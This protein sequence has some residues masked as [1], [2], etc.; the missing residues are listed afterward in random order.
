MEIFHKREMII[1]LVIVLALTTSVWGQPPPPLTPDNS[2]A[3]YRPFFPNDLFCADIIGN[4][5]IGK[6]G[7][8]VGP[9]TLGETTLDDLIAM[10]ADSFPISIEEGFG[11]FEVI[12]MAPSATAFNSVIYFAYRACV[13]DGRIIVVEGSIQNILNPEDLIELDTYYHSDDYTYVPPTDFV[14]FGIKQMV[15]RYGIPD[16]VTYSEDPT[17][18][19]AFWFEQGI[20]GAFYVEYDNPISEYPPAFG[21]LNKIVYFPI[22]EVEGYENRYPFNRTYPEEDYMI[23]FASWVSN[24]LNVPTNQNPFNFD[25]MLESLTPTPSP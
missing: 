8:T 20:A 22:Q 15:E 13:E 7:T 10:Y 6:I 11:E 18:R 19:V 25:A 21:V 2:S 16:V 5:E 17:L 23:E 24:S 3:S 1:V 12:I 14:P 9:I 4:N